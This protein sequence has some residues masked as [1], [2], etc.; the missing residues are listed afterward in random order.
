MASREYE[1]LTP[2]NPLDKQRLGESVV[3]ALMER[4]TAPLGEIDVFGGAGVYAIYYNGDFPLYSEY[5]TLNRS[6]SK[7]FPIYVGKAVS[8]G[9]RKGKFGLNDNPGAALFMRLK[10]HAQ[11]IRLAQNLEIND[12]TCRFLAVDEIWI[13]LAESLLISTYA[14][15]WN[16]IVD[17]FGN[18]DPG[19][20]RYKQQKSQWDALHPGREWAEKLQE[21]A[22]PKEELIRRV[23]TY[24]S[25]K[26]QIENI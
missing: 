5:K 1:F 18:H 15:L 14:P 20:G 16:V 12:F 19:G 13:P 2:Y 22:T 9:A 7:R 26:R 17:G 23:Q 24:F 4:P 10:E 6:E 11:S 25:T 8:P 3:A 21:N